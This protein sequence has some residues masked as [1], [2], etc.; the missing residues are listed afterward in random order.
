MKKQVNYKVNGKEWEEAK[1]RAFAKLVK[2]VK[3]DGFREGKV[4]RNVFEKKFGTGDI[5]SE[6]MQDVLDKK[7]T[8]T[9]IN[10]KLIPVVDPKLEIVSMNDEGFEANITFI[11]DP[12]VKLG[13]YKELKVK[14]DKVE[15]TKEV[16]DH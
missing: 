1:D 11:L 8:E 2:K 16:I 9:V 14:K 15:V 5:I 3:V 4:P 7:Y 12:E 6:A 10:E 13:K